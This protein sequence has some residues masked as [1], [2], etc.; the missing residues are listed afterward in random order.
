MI[1]AKQARVLTNN[2]NANV[3]A[4]VEKLSELIEVAAN[5]GK[6]EI[7][8]NQGSIS[9]DPTKSEEVFMPEFHAPYFK[10]PVFWNL[11]MAKLKENGYGVVV[12]RGEAYIPRGESNQMHVGFHMKIRW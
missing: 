1:N 4:F 9:G 5:N 8:Y 7:F 2:S 12:E 11:V 10:I 6:C 3:D